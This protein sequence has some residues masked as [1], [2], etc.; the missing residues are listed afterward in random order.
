MAK[1]TANHSFVPKKNDE[2][3]WEEC[4]VCG[5]KKGEENH[6][7]TVAEVNTYNHVLECVCGYKSG[8]LDHTYEDDDQTQCDVCAH[9]RTE[10]TLAFKSAMTYTATTYNGET[11]V[12][13][14]A[15][16]AET[17][18]SLDDVIVE[19]SKSTNTEP[20]WITNPKDAGTYYIRL[21]VEA[22]K[23]H[24]GLSIDSLE[25]SDKVLTI[26]PKTLSLTDVV[27]VCEYGELSSA[28]LKM[29]NL[30]LTTADISGICANDTLTASLAWKSDTTFAAGYEYDVA[31]KNILDSTQS[32]TVVANGNYT[33]DKTTT[34][35]LYV[36]NSEISYEDGKF[37]D[38]SSM[39]FSA[40]RT[41]YWAIEITEEMI[42]E[43][44]GPI[45]ISGAFNVTGTRSETLTLTVGVYNSEGD[46]KND[47][48]SGS[49]EVSCDGLTAGRYFIKVTANEACVGSWEIS[50]A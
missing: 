15:D 13:D 33:F 30:Y 39:T 8:A 7:F 44:G 46:V 20:V 37:K 31:V 5:Y 3:H 4:R 35:K 1:D 18:V 11:Q 24:T 42:T 25:D 12:F 48:T 2:K 23:D 26:N 36:V 10:T 6:D 41:K 32:V 28:T 29:I 21:R 27:F 17:N 9:E 38:D 40:G 34:G 19:Y 45:S 50:I 22:N 43:Y 16:L 14:K 47:A 49:G